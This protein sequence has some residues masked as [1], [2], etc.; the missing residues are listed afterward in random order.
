MITP[1]PGSEKVI[2]REGNE[3][4]VWAVLL[5][6]STDT[7]PT[8]PYVNGSMFIEMDTGTSYWFNKATNEWINEG[9]DG[10]E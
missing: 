3:V 7:K 8:T 5:G 9:G 10:N 4:E 6:L 2:K 1:L